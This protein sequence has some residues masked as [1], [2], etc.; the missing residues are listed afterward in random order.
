MNFRLNF[1]LIFVMY[2]MLGSCFESNAATLARYQL[3]RVKLGV[4]NFRFKDFILPDRQ[5]HYSDG[6]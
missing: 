1:I 5:M 4:V 2:I 6:I 3:R